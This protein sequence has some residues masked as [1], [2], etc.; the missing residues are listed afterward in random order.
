MN[1][2]CCNYCNDDEEDK[3]RA[4]Y[5]I[6]YD[7]LIE[8]LEKT[9]NEIDDTIKLL[10]DKKNKDDI[11]N[12][13]LSEEYEEEEREKTPSKP[14]AK[15]LL[16]ELIKIQQKRIPYR[17]YETTPKDFLFYPPWYIKF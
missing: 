8:R 5:S 4:M 17:Y 7:S 14:D 9:R 16:D 2:N 11:I 1:S 12:S 3:S 6:D 13:I 15:D 10:K